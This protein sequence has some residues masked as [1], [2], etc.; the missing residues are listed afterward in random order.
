[1]EI[2]VVQTGD[3]IDKIAALYGVS[4]EKIIRD[5]DLTEPDQLIPGEAI[6]IVY[7]LQTYTV[8]EGDT[9]ESIA[10]SHEISVSELLRNNPFLADAIYIYPGEVLTISF[11]RTTSISTYGYANTFINRQTLRKTLPYLTYLSIFNYQIGENGNLYGSDED[12]DIIQL[13]VEYGTIP[14][15][16][17]STITVQGEIDLKLTYEVITNEEVQNKLFDNVISVLEKKGYYGVIVTAQYI[18]AEEQE[19]FINYTRRFSE[20]LNQEGYITLIAIDPKISTFGNEVT[21]E[22]LDYASIAPVVYAIILLQYRWGISSSPPGPI[23][24]VS[25]LNVFLD[26]VLSQVEPDK[27]VIGIPAIG[28]I[29]ELPYVVGFSRS[30]S[31]TLDNALSLA[32][33]VGATIQF[34]IPSQTPYFTYEDIA[35]NDTEYIVWF[36]D[37]IT[38]ESLLNLILARGISGTGAWNIMSYFAQLWLVIN[39]QYEI[40]KLLPE[41]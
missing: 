7:P 11:Q 18:T 21:Y 3:T 34:D 9:L 10:V 24:S 28:Q 41:F 39:S 32:R 14:L 31:I 38:I 17:I 19:I 1:M 8:Q 22:N 12:I 29:W 40:I 5:N 6:V 37:A 30:N 20:R 26:Y 25:E 16:H 23:I 13:A 27:L 2:Y 33:E 35:E 15:M 4:A 36:I